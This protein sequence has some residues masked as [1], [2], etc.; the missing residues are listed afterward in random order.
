MP[1]AGGG[2]EQCYN[3]QA[4]LAAGSLLVVAGDVVQAPNDQHQ[5]QP[6]LLA[7][8]TL[9]GELGKP[10]TLLADTGYFSEANVNA[11]A[12]AGIDRLIAQRRLSHYPPMAERTAADPPARESPRRSRRWHIGCRPKVSRSSMGCASRCRNWCSGSSN[13]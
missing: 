9:P 4:L 3:A 12:A 2:F 7:L 11:W 13:R 5:V 8:A 1:M 6:T 10:E